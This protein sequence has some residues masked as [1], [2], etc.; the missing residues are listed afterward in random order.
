M[1]FKLIWPGKTKEPWLREGIKRYVEGINTMGRAEIIEIKEEKGKPVDTAL[2]AEGERILKQAGGNF[3]LLDEK[4]IKMG[5]EEFARWLEKSAE[6]HFVVGGA[7]GVSE[8]VRK[9]ARAR[10][11]FSSMAFPHELMRV[12]LLEQLYRALTIQKGKGYHH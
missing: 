5:S 11:S 3:V 8:E 7:Y 4:G 12:V 10:L 9:L 6:W 1:R 2:K